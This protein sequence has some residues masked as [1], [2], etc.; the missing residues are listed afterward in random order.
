MKCGACGSDARDAARFCDQCGAPLAAAAARPV[1]AAYTPRHLAERIL[2][3]RAALL[4][5]RKP[6]TVLFADI[7]GSMAL[8]EQIDPEQWHELMNRFFA[9]L[10]EG[11]HRFEGTVNQYTGDGIMALFGAPLAHEDHAQ[12]ACH[13]AWHLAAALREYAQTLR[14]ERGLQFSVRMGLNSGEVVVGAIGDDLRMDYTAQGHT[15]GLAARMEQLC[16][17]GRVYLSAHTAALVEGYFTLEDLGP[18]TIKGAREPLRVYAL[19]G[20]GPLRTRLDAARAR[21][22]SP[23]VG[24]AAELAV[25]EQAVADAA[26]GN[27]KPVALI[28]N[29]GVGKSRLFLELTARCRARGMAVVESSALA[30]G[31]AVPYLPVLTLLR[32]LLGLDEREAPESTRRKIAGALLLLDD[33]FKPRL[34]LLF[35]MLGVPDTTRPGAAAP[36]A[37]S[38]ATALR[39]AALALLRAR[40]DRVPAVVVIED[41]HWLD[42]ASDAFLR[43]LAAGLAGSRVA[44]VVDARPEYDTAWLRAAGAAVLHLAPLDGADAESLLDEL[45]GPDASL[46]G[47][48]KR[49]LARAAGNPF[50]LEELVRG[51]AQSGVL[52]GGRGTYT[53]AGAAAEVALPDT[54]HAVLAARIDRL[55]AADKD[56][57]QCAAVI[58]TSFVAPLLARVSGLGAATLARHLDTLAAAE[59]LVREPGNGADAYAFAHPLTQEVAYAAQL[60]ARRAALHG[61]VASALVDEAQDAEGSG[62]GCVAAPTSAERAALTAYHWERGGVPLEAARWH[63]HTARALSGSAINEAVDRLRRVESLLAPLPP[64]G[65]VAVLRVRSVDDLLRL[66]I[67]AAVSLAEAEQLFTTARALAERGPDRAQLA[68]LLSTYGD[69]LMMRGSIAASDD[70]LREAGALA[71]DVDDPPMRL[72]L[73]LDRAQNDFWAGRLREALR[74]F[75][76][77]ARLLPLTPPSPGIPV[78][79][80]GEAFVAGMRGLCLGLMGRLAEGEA[81]IEHSLQ[82]AD[83][84]GTLEGRCMARQLA[85]FLANVSG[86]SSR[87]IAYAQAARELAARAANPVLMAMSDMNLGAALALAGQTDDAIA[88][89][90]QAGDG[91]G[92]QIGMLEWFSLPLLALALRDRGDYAEALRV[93]EQGVEVARGAQALSAELS[94]QMALCSALTNAR[95]QAGG[96][97]SA[98]ALTRA[99]EL[100]AR[101]GAEVFRPRWHFTRGDRLRALGDEAGYRA[102]LEAGRALCVAL[103]MDELADRT[104]RELAE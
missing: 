34:P 87:G 103:G 19:A 24:R 50:F 65:E 22:L 89:L 100:L 96:E 54:V 3:S 88:L 92:A 60:Q 104:A 36:D 49:L 25:L 6:V 44:L 79:L 77:G 82:L 74:G 11:V 51:L 30:H 53:L 31:A 93:A 64:E 80:V 68:Q 26:S 43:E 45:L 101:T 8:A 56:V 37:A 23:F 18:F 28:G 70:Y 16:E 35:D 81:D 97:A 62:N 90:T 15:V 98:A 21:G 2:T 13:A 33:G 102:A 39:D 86:R 73:V 83:E 58:G 5:E 17:P 91:G 76:E 84:R 48:R 20:L 9:I 55:A 27:A 41:L 85:A 32:E 94:A 57:L 47:L 7:K 99:E 59:L 12:R 63:H 72:N 67:S 75:E 69:F 14:R 61:A 1:P 42:P 29:A 46:A 52:A 4:G 66:G 38:L 40:S 95:P 71:H 10:S 78:G